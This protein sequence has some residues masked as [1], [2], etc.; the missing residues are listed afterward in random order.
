MS[1]DEIGKICFQ[2]TLLEYQ[3]TSILHTCCGSLC[4]AGVEHNMP[5]ASPAVTASMLT[6]ENPGPEP[7]G[8]TVRPSANACY[9]LSN[10]RSHCSLNKSSLEETGGRKGKGEI[11][12]L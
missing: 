11:I 9:L 1:V 7:L 3:E 12:S 2:N 5:T 8:V 10:P 4:N 6:M